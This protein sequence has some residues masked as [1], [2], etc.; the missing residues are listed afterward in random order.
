MFSSLIEEGTKSKPYIIQVNIDYPERNREFDIQRVFKMTHNSSSRNGFH[1]R[2]SIAVLDH[3]LWEATI[4]NDL[5]AVYANR[6]VL[7]KGPAQ[8]FWMHHCRNHSEEGQRSRFWLLL[9]PVGIILDDVFL[10]TG[11]VKMIEHNSP[12]GEPLHGMAVYWVIG[13][14]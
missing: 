5:P 13:E 14:T 10:E 3:D 12:I 11:W 8:D 7:I 9:F 2:R 4:P 1:I 6:A